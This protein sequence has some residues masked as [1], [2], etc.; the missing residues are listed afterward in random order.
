M[1]NSINVIIRNEVD[2]PLIF[3]D[4]AKDVVKPHGTGMPIKRRRHVSAD[5]DHIASNTQGPF[6]R[7]P[8]GAEARDLMQQQLQQSISIPSLAVIVALLSRFA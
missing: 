5:E 1:S 2:V 4:Y 3:I 6:A 8:H 7:C